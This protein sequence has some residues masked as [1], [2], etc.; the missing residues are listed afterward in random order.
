MSP[1]T[2]MEPTAKTMAYIRSQVPMMNAGTSIS[3][4]RRRFGIGLPPLVSHALAPQIVLGRPCLRLRS[5]GATLGSK[6]PFQSKQ[7]DEHREAISHP[8]H[9]TPPAGNTTPGGPVLSTRC[10]GF[11]TVLAADGSGGLGQGALDRP[12]EAEPGMDGHALYASSPRPLSNAVGL[13]AHRD[14]VVSPARRIGELLGL[15]CCREVPSTT[16]PVE[17]SV[18]PDS[19]GHGPLGKRP[20]LAVY[21]QPM[22]V[23]AV[24]G[25]L[26]LGSPPDVPR[27]V[28]A[29]IVDAIHGVTE[30]W[31]GPDVTMER[32][33]AVQ[34]RRMNG[35]AA[36]AVVGVARVSG[37]EASLLHPSP[38]AVLAGLAQPVSHASRGAL[39]VAETA[40][41][42]RE[43]TLQ[44]RQENAQEISAIAS[45]FNET[46][47]LTSCGRANLAEQRPATNAGAEQVIDRAPDCHKWAQTTTNDG[48]R[49]SDWRRN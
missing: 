46:P 39:F 26:G 18:R 14:V 11:G 41:G 45:A 48:T 43:S 47:V 5:D 22:V 23:A 1:Q 3:A 21:S 31:R 13:I 37:I 17:E 28:P 9:R 32:L 33:K 2:M 16:Q 38:D 24:V 12:A 19:G 15:D 49:W 30:G 34:P 42:A 36:P 20:R 35:D 25:L 27:L 6:Q 29:V 40:A 10:D 8:S 44:I 7:D 4:I